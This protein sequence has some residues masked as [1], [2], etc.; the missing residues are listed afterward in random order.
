LILFVSL[1]GKRISDSWM[2]PSS[3][4]S[5]DKSPISRFIAFVLYCSLMSL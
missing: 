2:P 1:Y 4:L 5:D 3:H